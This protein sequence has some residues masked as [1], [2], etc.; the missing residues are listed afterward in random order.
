MKI[1]IEL[2][3]ADILE[4][5]ENIPPDFEIRARMGDASPIIKLAI[6]LKTAYERLR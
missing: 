4:A 1:E 3:E 2:D 5:I 6:A